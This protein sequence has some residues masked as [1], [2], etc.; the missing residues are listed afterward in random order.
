MQLKIGTPCFVN[1]ND[2]TLQSCPHIKSYNII[3]IDIMCRQQTLIP[4]RKV[5]NWLYDFA[6]FLLTNDLLYI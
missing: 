3:I 4:R 5:L 2:F 6:I 1:N